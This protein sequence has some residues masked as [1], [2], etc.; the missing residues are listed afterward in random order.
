METDGQSVLTG[1]DGEIGDTDRALGVGDQ[2][3]SQ[4]V[5]LRWVK[6]GESLGKDLIARS[7]R[8]KFGVWTEQTSA[9][10]SNRRGT[11]ASD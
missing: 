1:R 2:C 7:E 9:S 10:T 6:M 4:L 5:A 3:A 11:L 8:I